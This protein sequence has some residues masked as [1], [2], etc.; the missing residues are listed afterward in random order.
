MVSKSCKSECLVLDSVIL[1]LTHVT[2]SLWSWFSTSKLSKTWFQLHFSNHQW[3]QPLQNLNRKTQLKDSMSVVKLS[4][5]LKTRKLIINMS[6][7]WQRAVFLLTS[8]HSTLLHI[9]CPMSRLKTCNLLCCS[10]LVVLITLLISGINI[11][12][13]S[14]W[15]LSSRH[16][17]LNRSYRLGCCSCKSCFLY[18]WLL[19]YWQS[20]GLFQNMLVSASLI[21]FGF[22]FEA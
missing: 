17:L 21:L 15:F 9:S 18:P 7:P 8:H 4:V 13:P 3:R 10:S 11:L 12:V 22:V 14:D 19:L 1:H 2:V 16:V 5:S 6:Q 20:K